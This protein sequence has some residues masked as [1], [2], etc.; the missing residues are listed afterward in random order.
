MDHSDRLS[1]VLTRFVSKPIAPVAQTADAAAM[2]RGEPGLPERFSW[3]QQEYRILDVME[4]WTSI[5]PCCSGSREKYRRKHWY[6]IRTE[7][8]Q[9]M[10]IYCDRQPRRGGCAKSRWWIYI[11]DVG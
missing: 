1:A 9:I 2:S 4:T 6:R 10:T 5:G 11:V 3:R 7:P 8:K